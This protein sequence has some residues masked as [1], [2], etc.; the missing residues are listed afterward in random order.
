MKGFGHGSRSDMA[1]AEALKAARDAEPGP[2]PAHDPADPLGLSPGDLVNVAADD[3]GRDPIAGR[4]V[5]LTPE[6]VVIARPTQDLG[7]IHVHFPRIG[8]LIARV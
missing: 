6:R 5:A 2:A 4:L 7:R 1:P 8:Y 3:Y